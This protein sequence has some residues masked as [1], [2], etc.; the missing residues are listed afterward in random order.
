V[1]ATSMDRMIDL[2]DVIAEG[3]VE[4]ID[5][6]GL[7]DPNTGASIKLACLSVGR[8]LKS[9]E[10]V[11][12]QKR[13]EICV[14]FTPTGSESPNFQIHDSYLVFLVAR[15]SGYAPLARHRGVLRVLDNKVRTVEI[16]G[17]PEWQDMDLLAKRISR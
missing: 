6:S 13:E 14:S 17:D 1:L 9:P 4:H 3:T 12:A 10:D 15:S 7:R 5:D 2:S 11:Q 16:S 8:L